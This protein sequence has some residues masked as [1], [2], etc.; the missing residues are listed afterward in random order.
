M[1]KAVL[2]PLLLVLLLLGGWRFFREE[3]PGFRFLGCSL[4]P[5]ENLEL[6]LSYSTRKGVQVTLFAPGGENLDSA[7]LPENASTASLLFSPKGSSPAGGTYRLLFQHG[8]RKVAENLLI[9]SGPRVEVGE[10]VFGWRRE[11]W[12]WENL[13]REM[14]RLYPGEDPERKLEESIEGLLEN[15]PWADRE[16]VLENHCFNFYELRYV[17]VRLLNA[18]DLP[19]YVLAVS[20]K[21]ENIL[22]GGQQVGEWVV[23]GEKEWEWET[24]SFY[25]LP[26]TRILTVAVLED[27]GRLL[28]EDTRPLSVP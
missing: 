26:G 19:A 13:L 10:A 2:L 25:S 20:W 12:P 15:Y 4:A 3:G 7:F 23:P 16:K 28:V 24:S 27:W 18:G 17:R 22:V 9:F 1:R 6:E 5:G 8:G 21:L 11:S 14:R